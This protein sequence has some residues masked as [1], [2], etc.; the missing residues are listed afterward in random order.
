M[1]LV[2]G[3]GFRRTQEWGLRHCV[4]LAQ[5]EVKPVVFVGLSIDINALSGPGG[6][7]E[8]LRHTSTRESTLVCCPVAFQDF[9]IS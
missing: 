6:I 9:V 2:T 3:T 1:S 8:F 5:G 4:C 7:V